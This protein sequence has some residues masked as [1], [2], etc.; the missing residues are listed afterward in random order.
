MLIAAA[1]FSILVVL[2]FSQTT[3]AQ[4]ASAWL[5]AAHAPEPQAGDPGRGQALFLGKAP[6]ENDGPPCMACHNVGGSGLLGGGAVGPDLTEMSTFYRAADLTADLADMPW[7]AMEPIYA[8]HPLTP[9]EQADLTAF[10]LTPR[11]PQSNYY[12]WVVMGVGLLGCI[13]AAGFFG[14]MYRRRMRGVRQALVAQ[15]RL[16]RRSK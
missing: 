7:P 2:L 5:P 13:A 16:P 12:A 1:S 8:E 6:L 15:G 9:S 4:S 11:Q 3:P 10:L 14:L